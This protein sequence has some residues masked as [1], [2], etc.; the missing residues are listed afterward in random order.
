MDPSIPGP[1]IRTP[2]PSPAT[3]WLG[4]APLAWSTREGEP[5]AGAGQL[6]GAG[7]P[8]EGK[9]LLRGGGGVGEQPLE[10]SLSESCVLS[11]KAG[12]SRPTAVTLATSL[13]PRGLWEV[14]DREVGLSEGGGKSSLD[15]A[16]RRTLGSLKFLFCLSLPPATKH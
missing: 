7:L 11:L 8:E 1:G 4:E 2:T 12:E 10:P 15:V 3:A 9:T 6:P 5:Q 13:L 14:R 16:L